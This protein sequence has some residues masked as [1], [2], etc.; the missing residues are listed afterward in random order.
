MATPTTLLLTRL[1]THEDKDSVAP[2]IV[3]CAEVA[4]EWQVLTQHWWV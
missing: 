2:E 4:G 3:V 1:H